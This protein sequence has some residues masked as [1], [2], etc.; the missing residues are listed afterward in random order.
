MSIL[1]LSIEGDENRRPAIT[2]ARWGRSVA[3]QVPDQKKTIEKFR[4]DRFGSSALSLALNL[5]RMR[6]WAEYAPLLLSVAHV[7]GLSISIW[8]TARF[9]AA[10]IVCS[11]LLLLICIV[12]YVVL[13]DVL[14]IHTYN[15][16]KLGYISTHHLPRICIR[17]LVLWCS[18][19]RDLSAKRKICDGGRIV[20]N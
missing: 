20:Y 6:F 10:I 14:H 12:I 19:T 2:N 16:N 4:L 18:T 5:S 13:I 3:I 11:T 9:T 8:L 17:Q 1:T 7:W 15:N